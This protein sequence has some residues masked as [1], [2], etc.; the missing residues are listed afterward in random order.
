[1]CVLYAR[2]SI[3]R[4]VAEAEL[5]HNQAARD[6]ATSIVNAF[7]EIGTPLRFVA[8]EPDIDATPLP[9]AAPD[10]QT[11][12]AVVS[13]ALNDAEHLLQSSGPVS[14]VD[15]VHTALHGYLRELCVTAQLEVAAGES[16]TGLWKRLR[17]EHPAFSGQSSQDGHLI[18]VASGLATIL[19]ALNPLRNT[20]SVAHPN[21][22]LLTEADAM[23][24]VNAARTILHFVD[25]RVRGR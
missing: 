20:G 5:E 22:E 9:V 24:A 18:R 14:A 16:M 15:R 10:V 12:A 2:L 3:D 1:L 7:A 17:T 8:F 6:A 4:Y 25:A 21:E 19:D 13:R 11:T 23:L